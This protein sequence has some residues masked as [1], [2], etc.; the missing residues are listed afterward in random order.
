[1]RA[2][3]RALLHVGSLSLWDRQ[4][5]NAPPLL[6]SPAGLATRR[7]PHTKTRLG[8]C[9]KTPLP[10]NC[11]WIRTMLGIVRTA[12]QIR[13]QGACGVFY[14]GLLQTNSRKSCCRAYELNKQLFAQTAPPPQRGRGRGCGAERRQW[15]MQRGGAPAA[16]EKIEQASSA[17]IFSGTA[18]RWGQIR[19]G[20]LWSASVRSTDL[21][22]PIIEGKTIFVSSTAK[23]QKGLSRGKPG[24]H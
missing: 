4:P 12:P 23:R 14:L 11:G 24:P 6:L 2:S 19:R 22:F 15:R 18:R 17:K 8:L 1:M 3:S 10:L 20:Y 7:G 9:P 21:F 16:V 5:S 13:S